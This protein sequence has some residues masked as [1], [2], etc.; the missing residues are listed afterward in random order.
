MQSLR[1]TDPVFYWWKTGGY[2]SEQDENVLCFVS[3]KE[4]DGQRVQVWEGPAAMKCYYRI[5]FVGV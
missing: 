4:V 5:Q 3:Y 1:H 2:M